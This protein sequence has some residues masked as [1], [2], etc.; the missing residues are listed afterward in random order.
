MEKTSEPHE[1]TFVRGFATSPASA[2]L[3]WL[4]REARG[5]NRLLRLPL[6]LERGGSGFSLRGARIGG[7][8][9]A[10]EV[11]AN[12]SALGIGLADRAASHCKDRPTCA[13]VVAAYWQ[14][15]Q[16]GAFQIDV[17]EV[18]DTIGA[19]ALSKANHVEIE[20]KPRAA[21]ERPAAFE[22]GFPL[23]AGARKNPSLGG[24]TSVAPGKNYTLSVYDIDSPIDAVSAFYEAHL[25][26]AVRATEGHEVRWSN[27]A[28]TVRLA[29]LDKGTRITI[30]VGPR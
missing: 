8:S 29:R 20:E 17:V 25:P 16:G 12:D 21:I 11:Y 18:F 13:F 19:D 7:S 15:R 28:G 27:R 24:A 22:Q 6:V 4:D 3:G 2:L 10:I 1:R 5:V 23:P 14:G 9:D 26:E 30:V